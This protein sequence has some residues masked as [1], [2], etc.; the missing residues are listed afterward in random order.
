MSRSVLYAWLMFFLTLA[1]L[2]KAQPALAA[3]ERLTRLPNGLA[4]Y[5][6][7]DARF[8]LVCTRLYVNT[9]SAKETAE[10]AGISHLLEH[11]VFKGTDHRPKGQ[12]ARD[13]EELGGYINATTGFD[14]TTYIT[15][16][17]AAH[18]RTGMDV[19]KD[20]AFQATLDPE[21]LEKEKEVV[22]SEMEIGEDSPARR[23][24][25]DLQTAGLRSTAY[26]RPIIGFRDSVRAVTAQD[27]RAYITRWYQPQNM[28]LL[29]AGDIDLDAVLAHAEK[30]FGGM[31]NN[32]ALSAPQ[33]TNPADA[34]GGPRIAITKGS[35][36]KAY[37][38]LAFPVPGLR[39]LRSVD[40]DVLAHL[41][42]GDETSRFYRKYKYEKQLVDSISVHN[43]SLERAGLLTITA[44]LDVEK[45]APFWAEITKDLAAL[46]AAA[47]DRED[48]TRAAFNLEDDMDRAAETLSGLASWRGT[49]RFVLG[50][51]QA[52]RN[53][54]FALRTADASRLRRAVDDWIRPERAR[55]RILVPRDAELPDMGEILDKNWPAPEAAPARK[56]EQPRTGKG[57]RLV[58]DNGR[59]VILIPD[60]TVPYVSLN[61][62]MPGGNALIRARDQGLAELTARTLTD[63][64]AD[65][66]AL[67]FNR[68][69]SQRAA[70]V[71]AKAGL[72]T[73]SLSMT[74][75]SRFQADY[76]AMLE[77]MLNRPRFEEAEIRREA[78]TM[79]S[80]IRQREDT[81]LPYLFAKLNPFLFSGNHVYGFDGL[82]TPQ[83]LDRFTGEDIR[84]FWKGQISQPWVL[85]IA[86]DFDG[87]AVLAMV[88]NLPSAEKSTFS[89]PAPSWGKERNLALNLPG[90]NQAHLL[91]LFKAVPLKH[92]DAP[93]LM[94]LQT[95]LSGQ[96]G[97]LFS[98]LRDEQS[99]GYSV[100]AFYRAMPEAGFLA[101]YI[102]TTPDKI[103]QAGQGFAKTVEDLRTKPLPEK[104]LKAAGNR[105]LGDYY[106]ERQSL[107]SRAG[108][109][110]TDAVLNYPADFHRELI[111]RA[112]AL[113]PADIQDTA[114]RYL[115]ADDAYEAR[116]LP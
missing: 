36:K 95:I 63:G 37:M 18:W 85:S 104:L 14:K 67:N 9:G 71:N 10:Q 28:M 41:L 23:L 68:F 111:A 93:A 105:L 113:T 12:A 106:R 16:M 50:G 6:V 7:R 24:F 94:L 45:I 110:A 48:I 49:V 17:P 78:N 98:T 43:M 52:E 82:G 58:L 99:L 54:R 64:C 112:A 5:L 21:E 76:F 26:G 114:K 101:F 4:V 56:A 87:S 80:A 3:E 60:A 13:V 42:G 107:A 103:G 66:D 57:E 22:I 47:F 79:K 19:V 86:G 109:A 91:R 40:L 55:L 69:F 90:R 61:L 30:L 46:K 97:L 51:E 62:T 83:N 100:T 32:A 65:F 59:A 73:F 53:M 88:K 27:L 34:A 33:E 44:R 84:A 89:V 8:P 92:R 38:G 116:L 29:V 39:D 31:E 1:A 77:N 25:E 75:P 102:G 11:M 72:Q 2:A 96:S 20:M 70:S 15:D 108:E 74:G 115:T 81:P 35:W